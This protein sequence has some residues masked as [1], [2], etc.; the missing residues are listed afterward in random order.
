MADP[1]TRYSLPSSSRETRRTSF[2]QSMR[3]TK[4]IDA[5]G[6]DDCRE[7]AG[8]HLHG[9][10]FTERCGALQAASMA[11]F[12]QLR[13]P[14]VPKEDDYVSMKSSCPLART[15]STLL[16]AGANYWGGTN[17]SPPIRLLAKYI[18]TKSHTGLCRHGLRSDA[19]AVLPW[20]PS[21]LVWPRPVRQRPSRI[22]FRR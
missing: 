6:T 7:T 10:R 13:A 1:L 21:P 17:G 4:P 5:V 8:D 15:S 19:S 9:P 12:A 11:Q 20:S 3:V 18:F 16:Q 22:V 14:L 2:S